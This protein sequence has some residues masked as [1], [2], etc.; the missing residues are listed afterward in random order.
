MRAGISEYSIRELSLAAWLFAIH[1]KSAFCRLLSGFVISSALTLVSRARR[2][3]ADN[4]FFA[5]FTLR[6]H[7]CRPYTPI[8]GPGYRSE[9]NLGEPDIRI[10]AVRRVCLNFAFHSRSN[11][12][13][14]I[15]AL[16]GDV[17]DGSHLGKR[18]PGRCG[19]ESNPVN[20]G[21]ESIFEHAVQIEGRDRLRIDPQF[22]RLSH[23][24]TSPRNEADGPIST[25]RSASDGAQNV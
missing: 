23:R 13:D 16:R 25:F 5:M 6:F 9:E 1:A 20:F 19:Y 11:Q 24:T 4:F 17:H 7:S 18:M 2:D 21:P 12:G 22:A 15:S 14:V 3:D 8:D 10:E